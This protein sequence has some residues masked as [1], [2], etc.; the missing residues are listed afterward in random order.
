MRTVEVLSD[1]TNYVVVRTEGRRHPGL[2]VQGDRLREWLRLARA[3][4][5]T[6]VQLLASQLAE[7]IAEYDRVCDVAE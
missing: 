3:A 5:L 6:S 7:S 4:D 2:I 1:A